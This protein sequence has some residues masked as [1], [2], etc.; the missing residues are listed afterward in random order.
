MKIFAQTLFTL[1]LY[2]L[3][4]VMIGLAISPGIALCFRIW[5]ITNGVARLPRI[6]ALCFSLVTAYFIY[7]FYIIFITAAIRHGFYDSYSAA[8]AFF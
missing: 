3:G 4:I 6:L 5:Q 1:F 8:A 7:G 2:L